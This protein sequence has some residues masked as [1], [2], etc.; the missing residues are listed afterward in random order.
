MKKFLI[1]IIS[2]TL[3][4]S[5]TACTP[6]DEKPEMIETETLDADKVEML[7]GE[8]LEVDMYLLTADT[9]DG[10]GEKIGTITLIETP[11]GLILSPNLTKLPHG[12]F[13]FHVH[14]NPSLGAKSASGQ[15]SIG[16]QA[17][18]HYDPMNTK[19]HLGPNN[20]EGHFGDLPAIYVDANGETPFAVLAPRIKKIEDIN[21]KSFMIHAKNDN[22]SDTPLP[23][24]GSGSRMAG[25]I[26]TK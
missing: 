4:L 5:V 17:G 8:T 25:G 2:A 1:M 6:S 24:G 18:G 3:A 14:E 23:L 7:T 9:E 19:L 20:P 16:S 21:N 11:F 10:L 13:G 15:I 12:E 22:Y 26:I